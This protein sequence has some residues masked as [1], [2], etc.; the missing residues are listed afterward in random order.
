MRRLFLYLSRRQGLRRWMETSHMVEV[1][2]RRFVAGHTLGDALT[3]AGRLHGEKLLATV[4]QLGENVT[5]TAEANHF[6]G[7]IERAFDAIAE[8]RLPLTVSVK[9]TQLGLDLSADLCTANMEILAMKAAAQESRLEID[10]EDS[11]YVDRTIEMARI[12]HER[13]GHV[14][15]VLQAYLYRTEAD[16]KRLN[17]LGVPVRLC[18][19]AY[20]EPAAVAF[21]AK[22]DVDANYL[23]LAR[24]LLRDG[25][26]PAIATHD[27]RMIAGAIEAAKQCG[28]KADE[29]EFQM[30][31]GV[32][33]D[34]QT[35][36][37]AQ[38]YRVRLYVPFGVDWYPYFMRRL[39]ERPANV[40]FLMR[41]LLRA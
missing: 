29:F 10:M 40:A 3:V 21:P 38:G 33:R 13:C 20:D 30:L 26:Y 34:L 7:C 6:R 25:N 27:P 15:C 35:K 17:E 12:M 23:K 41:N 16:L 37:A 2:T 8:A 39:A 32:R 31:Y 28:R 5:T 36:L 18:K 4:D 19:G 24:I 14:R 9:L 22:T 11:S 1:L